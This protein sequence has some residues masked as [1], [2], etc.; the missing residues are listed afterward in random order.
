M[1]SLSFSSIYLYLGFVVVALFFFPVTHAEESG[2]DS[3][4][5]EESVKISEEV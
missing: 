2:F 4:A 3:T 1:H 5:Y